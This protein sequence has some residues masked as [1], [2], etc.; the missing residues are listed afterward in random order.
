MQ[1]ELLLSTETPEDRRLSPGNIEGVL[2]ALAKLTAIGN[3]LV[4][5]TFADLIT[6]QADRPVYGKSAQA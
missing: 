4:D 2:Q 1:P 5:I 3:P 6:R